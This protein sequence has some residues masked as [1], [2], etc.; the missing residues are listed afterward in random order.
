MRTLLLNPGPVTLSERVRRALARPDMCHREP[1]FAELVLSIRR[2]AE[3]LYAERPS[4]HDAI[5]V[6]GS[7]TCAVEAMVASLVPRDGAALVL[8][9]GVY[10]ERI[11]AMLA[12]HGKAHHVVRS[13]WLEPIDVDAAARALGGRQFSA[14]IAVHHETTTGR[15]NRL[16]AIG[17]LCRDAGVPLL[18]DAISSFGGEAIDWTGWHLGAVAATANKCLHGVPGIAVVLAD[19]D[20]LRARRGSSPALYLDLQRAHDDQ[21]SGFSPFTQ[22]VHACFA[23]DEALDEIADEGGWPARRAAYRR[24]TAIV[25]DGL[26]AFGVDALLPHADSASMLT[27]FRLPAGVDYAALH[28]SLKRAGFV[29]YAGQGPLAG[30]VFRIATMGDLTEDDME[31]LVAEIGRAARVAR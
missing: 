4:G 8:A 18:L 16:D 1:E 29:I 20:L 17:R 6:S 14:A 7:G 26:A 27:A 3:G 23:L 31:R 15:L 10:G 19:R 24:R 5:L 30:G 9:N 22:A 13:E 28:D 2:R 25:R 12:A 11:A 21:K